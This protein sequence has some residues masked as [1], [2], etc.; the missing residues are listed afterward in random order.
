MSGLGDYAT[1]IYGYGG[2]DRIYGTNM[3]DTLDGGAGDDTIVGYGGDDAIYGGSGDDTLYGYDGNDTLFGNEGDD[4][5]VGNAGDDIL[6]GNEGSDW[7]YGGTGN[8][9]LSG[10]AG[11]DRLYGEEGGDIYRFSSGDGNDTII[12]YES[13]TAYQDKVLFNNDVLKDTIALYQDGANLIIGYGNNDN[14]TVNYQE[15]SV[16]GIEKIEISNGQFMTD[17]DVNLVIQ[18][19][20]AFAASNGIPLTS[21]DD[22]KRNQDLMG[23]VVSA[24]HG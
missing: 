17:A 11:N 5:L 8:D 2:S 4:A 13:D 16:A 7:L 9:T 12:D 22:V 21:V 19:M 6:N 1:N 18:Q 15:S 23:M 3:N 10:N 14:I 24:W 20:T